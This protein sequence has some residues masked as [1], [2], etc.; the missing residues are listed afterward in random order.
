MEQKSRPVMQLIQPKS[1]FLIRGKPVR[2]TSVS[3]QS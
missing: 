3:A 1:R 2:I